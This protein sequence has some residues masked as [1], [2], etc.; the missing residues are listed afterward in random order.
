MKQ[1]SSGLGPLASGGT[2][3]V[4]GGGP[5]GTAAAI[6]LRCQGLALGRDIR[7]ILVE[8]KQFSGALHYNQCAGV[9]SPPIV[10]MLQN[11]LGVPF[12]RH[13]SQ[14]TISSYT[15]HTP[16]RQIL[17]EGAGEPSEALRRVQFDEYMLQAAVK[18]GV[19]VMNARMTDFEL[20][21][22]RVVVYTD[23]S[24]LD[25]DVV[26]GAFGMDEG[27]AEV[28]RRSVGYRSPPALGS[29]VTKYHPGEAAV[30]A[31]HGCIHV[32][33]P[34]AQ[35]IEFGAV[36]PKANHLT[37]NIAGQK[38]DADLM[39]D[40]LSLPEVQAVLPRLP[41]ALRNHPGD[42][43]YHKG[44]FPCGLAQR[45]SGD[46]FVLIGD[47]AGLV[48][49]FKG[50]GITSAIQ[51]G[52]RAAD[53]ILQEGIS[54]AAFQAFHRANQDIVA[55]LPYGQAVRWLTIWASRFGWMDLA[56]IAAQ[57]EPRLRTALFD[58]ASAHRP[59]REVVRA[60]LHPDSVRAVFG[61]L[62][63]GTA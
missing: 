29:V 35:N 62:L 45:Y 42:F 4:I 21:E 36:T 3:V 6:H 17:L 14:R 32:F 52:M 47:A 9:L 10:E 39:D 43:S 54:A 2:V 23:S 51:T 56:L 55:D 24:Q 28:F 34:R 59:Y 25:A 1:N 58:A 46:R 16:R 18:R 48:R 30:E 27:T 41:D 5:G 50:K 11:Q 13:L 57:K 8:G 31:M 40:F 33:L 61:A 20:H 60:C 15:L 26:I 44:R 7:V 49:A 38:V 37:I 19:T 12:P 22:N 63:R 53:V